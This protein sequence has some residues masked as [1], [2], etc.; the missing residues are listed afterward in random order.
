MKLTHIIFLIVD[1]IAASISDE[2][3]DELVKD[4]KY[5]SIAYCIPQGD[6]KEGELQTACPSSSCQGE[7]DKF[8]IFY[9]VAP[10]GGLIIQDD[11]AKEIIVVLKGTTNS[12]EWELDFRTDPHKY[13]PY[14]VMQGNNTENFNC[15]DCMVHAGFYKATGEVVRK[16]LPPLLTALDETKYSLKF[17]G[18]S[19]GAALAPLAANE[20]RMIGYLSSIVSFGGP[21]FAN[22][23]MADW[24]D[25]LWNTDEVVEAVNNGQS[26]DSYYLRVTLTNDV[27]PLVP[28]SYMGFA[29]SG[30]ELHLKKAKA[31]ASDIKVRG[32]WS[33]N[34]ENVDVKSTPKKTLLL[35][36]KK[37]LDL[38][39]A[40]KQARNIHSSYLISIN[41]CK[42]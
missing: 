37:R 21:K 38:V 32:R 5:S 25:D 29:H 26:M 24:M 10:V 33:K 36:K 11:T 27:V 41:K 8:V 22:Q 28:L 23:A 30:C 31:K 20:L 15:P 1:A 13:I 18:H 9:S 42:A 3:Y 6:M 16:F 17:T 19:L 12:K 40:T 7:T 14:T 4:A 34:I 39:M 2:L 35:L